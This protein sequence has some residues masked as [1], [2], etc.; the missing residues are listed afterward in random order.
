MFQKTY[1]NIY[2]FQKSVIFKNIKLIIIIVAVL[3]HKTVSHTHTLF[4]MFLDCVYCI[5]I[6]FCWIPPV[7]YIFLKCI[8]FNPFTCS[9]C[10]FSCSS[11]PSLCSSGGEGEPQHQCFN[12]TPSIRQPEVAAFVTPT[13]YSKL[14]INVISLPATF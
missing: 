5:C 10:S 13:G 14:R 9:T 7:F 2:I 4:L 12:R 11:F 8:S 1:N 6:V 3:S